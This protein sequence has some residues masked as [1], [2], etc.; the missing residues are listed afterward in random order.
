[1]KKVL[2]VGFDMD[3]VIL[4]N[5]IRF[6][7]SIA[8]SL[9]PLKAIIFKQ[10]K[11]TF[12]FPKSNIAKFLF[13][14]LHLS[15]YKIDTGIEMIKAL[16]KDKKIN[17]Y[18]ITSRYS[19]LEKSY[20]SW[21]KKINKNHIFTKCY[22]NKNDFQPNEFKLLMIKKLKLDYYV[23]DNWDIVEK[24]NAKKLKCK[25]LWITN[26]LDKNIQ[27]PYKFTSLKEACQFLKKN[28]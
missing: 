25:I 15:S 5:P 21:K 11:E 26:F 27:Y 14:A 3:G 17:A 19:F 10:K 12:Y 8:K 4:Y 9:K 28:G 2:K 18:I 7:R 20:L 22:N 1:M 13:S 16:V 24:L 23:E 6:V